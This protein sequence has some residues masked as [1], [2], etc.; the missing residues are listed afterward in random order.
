MKSYPVKETVT[1]CF[2]CAPPVKNS[3]FVG[4]TFTDGHSGLHKIS[5]IMHTTENWQLGNY[6]LVPS[7]PED[8]RRRMSYSVGPH[9]FIVCSNDCTF[10][11]NG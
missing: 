3:S 10:N 6:F 4:L 2:Q 9:I 11:S 5:N 7:V 1:N 8:S